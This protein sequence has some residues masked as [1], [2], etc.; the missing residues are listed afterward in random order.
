[1]P[2]TDPSVTVDALLALIAT[3]H[4]TIATLRSTID[5]Q[6]GDIAR[7]VTMVE[8]LTGQLDALLHGQAVA[9]RADLARLRAE[10]QAAA[11]SP[12]PGG[13]ADPSGGPA[14]A[15]PGPPP[16]PKKNL[17]PNRSKHGRGEVPDHL[18]RD[19]HTIPAGRCSQCPGEAPVAVVE[20]VVTEE[21]D[22][23]K[24]HVR[25]RRTERA[26]G[27]CTG[28]GVRVT[29]PQP[30]MPF[31]RASCTFALQAWLLYMK[32]G[33]FVPLD[34]LRRE[35]ERQ[36]ARIP[37][38]TA[39]RWWGRGADLLLPAAA[40]V[41]MSL[42][43]GSHIRTDGTG[44]RV[45]FPRMLVEPVKGPVRVGEADET[46]RLLAREPIYGQILVFGDDEHAVYHFTLTKEGRHAVDFLRV[47]ED[48]HGNAILWR[49]TITADAVSSQN[50]LFETGDRIESG[51]NSHGLR[52]FRDDVD[53]APL[54]AGRAM[55][56][57]G[58][59]YD[60]EAEARLK[61]KVGAEL[62][63]HRT[64]FA[65]PVVAEFKTWLAAHITD[66]LP[67]NPVRKAMQYYVNHWDAL[68]RFLLDP[69]VPLDNNWSERALRQIAM[70]RNNSMFAGG[71][72]GAVRLCTVLTLVQ[73][74][75]LIGVDACAYLE[76]ALQRSVPHPNNRHFV[77]S[78]LTPAAYKAAL[79]TG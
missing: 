2:P 72:E 42:L 51:C 68:T 35:L 44:L 54:L 17:S 7:L 24:A 21:Y 66:L 60:I 15:P 3:L 75:F 19:L 53:K 70:I 76:W 33:L 29:P 47:G 9:Q 61:K 71:E 6:R 67:S 34:R 27:R 30:P 58:R 23:V 37:S 12:A 55:A 62:L 11:K 32:C 39:T 63:A 16:D 22:Y 48:V 69:A 31:D 25:I 77:P 46:G 52:K 13:A 45:I 8:G 4:A 49:G 73:T 57:I 26:V 79:N 20:T 41:R 18:S 38:A 5:Q 64:E 56:F 59:V 43:A 28:C 10:A 1:M 40:C 14:P 78:D 50:C 74:C 65:S 36:G